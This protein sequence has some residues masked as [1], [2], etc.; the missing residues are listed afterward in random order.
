M[1]YLFGQYPDLEFNVL[2]NIESDYLEGRFGWSRQL[3]GGNYYKSV[4]R[5]LQAEKTINLCS[6]VSM[7]GKMHEIKT[8]FKECN[9]NKSLEQHEEK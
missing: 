9:M 2:G 7:G 3:C 4:T 5:F 1:H 6:L 8:I